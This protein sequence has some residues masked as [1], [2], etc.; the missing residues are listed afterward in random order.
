MTIEQAT[1]MLVMLCPVNGVRP[2]DIKPE[3]RQQ[4]V[5]ALYQHLADDDAF[6]PDWLRDEVEGVGIRKG[7]F[8]ERMRA[9]MVREWLERVGK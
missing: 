2:P 6:M 3:L 1:E 8:R 9:T 7:L 5:N 4:L